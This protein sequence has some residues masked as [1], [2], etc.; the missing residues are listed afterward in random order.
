MANMKLTLEYDG[1]GFHGWQ[2]QPA[3]RT[4]AGELSKAITTITGEAPRLVAAG[5]T[6]AGAHSLGQTVS[7]EL[8]RQVTPHRLMAGLNAV[9][10]EDV[11]VVEAEIAPEGFHARF[12]AK[13]RRYRYLV[14][15]REARSAV[16]RHHAWQVKSP[17]DVD[18]MRHAAGR[19]TGRRD[20]SAFGKDPAGRN[21]VRNLE[22]VNITPIS[23]G[24]VGAVIAFDLSA[25]AFLYG[26]VRRIVGFLVEVGSGRRSA[27]DAAAGARVAPARGLYQLAVEY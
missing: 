21:T 10:P 1:T 11:A 18:A 19:L 27:G 3:G 5:R 9:L 4:V 25:D 24:G 23:S 20:L 22:A 8:Q 13:R 16:L 26:M 7:F 6:D 2:A 12:S 14:E 17:L 15:N